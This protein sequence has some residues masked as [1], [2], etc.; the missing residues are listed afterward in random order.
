MCIFAGISDSVVFFHGSYT[1]F[2]LRNLAKIKYTTKTVCQGNFSETVQ[3][4]FMNMDR[5]TR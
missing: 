5:N 1:P 3:Q 2:E 4:N